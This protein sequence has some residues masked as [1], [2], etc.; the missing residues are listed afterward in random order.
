M[1]VILAQFSST[2]FSDG[3]EGIVR[4]VKASPYLKVCGHHTEFDFTP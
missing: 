4:L 3:M 2:G 1:A